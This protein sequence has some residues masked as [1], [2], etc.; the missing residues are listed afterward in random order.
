MAWENG[1][2][3]TTIDAKE[4]LITIYY[5]TEPLNNNDKSTLNFRLACS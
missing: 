5:L 4:Y 3:E 2:I 1:K